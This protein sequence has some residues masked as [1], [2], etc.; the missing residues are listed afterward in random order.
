MLMGR[1]RMMQGRK[2]GTLWYGDGCCLHNHCETCPVPDCV[3]HYG[4][5][6]KEQAILKARWDPY[7]KRE[8]KKVAIIEGKW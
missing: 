2:A 8:L 7:I 1:E 6:R 3:A 4:A 5:N